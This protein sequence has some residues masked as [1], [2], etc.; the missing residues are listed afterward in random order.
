MF[1]V[2]YFNVCY[3]IFPSRRRRFEVRGRIY[4]YIVLYMTQIWEDNCKGE[5]EEKERKLY[6]PYN[7][8]VQYKPYEIIIRR[9]F[10]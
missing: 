10:L 8:D 4:D 6:V 9:I 2:W 7:I 5:K 3:E 1:I